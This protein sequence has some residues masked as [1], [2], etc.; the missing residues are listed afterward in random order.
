M[1]NH[2]PILHIR[3]SLGSKFRFQQTTSISW[4]KFAPKKNPSGQKQ[5]K[6]NVTIESFIL[7]L[8]SAPNFRLN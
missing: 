6:I 8:V 5:Q 1:E 4:N 3:I 7:E 2:H